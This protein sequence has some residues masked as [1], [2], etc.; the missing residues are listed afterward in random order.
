MKRAIVQVIQPLLA[1]GFE[2]LSFG[3]L[4]GRGRLH[5]LAHAERLTVGQERTVWL[6]QDLK[7]AFDRVP[8]QRA[9]DLLRKRLPNEQLLD[10]IALVK[11]NGS[12]RGLLQGAP[13]S[14][15]ILNVFLDHLK[16][17]VWE[18][19]HPGLPSLRTADDT[20][21]L[22]RSKEE[23]RKAHEELQRILVPTGMM[24]KHAPQRAIRNL[25]TGDN[26]QWLG[27]DI[28]LGKRGLD[29]QPVAMVRAEGALR[30]PR[31]GRS[32]AEEY[33]SAVERGSGA[34]EIAMGLLGVGR[35]AGFS[36][37]EWGSRAGRGC[38]AATHPVAASKCRT[39]TA[40]ESAPV[41][42]DLLAGACRG[43]RPDIPSCLP[44]RAILRWPS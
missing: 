26:A 3:F 35:R 18:K 8:R 41:L 14:P 21:V 40:G 31:V 43:S 23:A 36:R 1:P 33:L 12:K 6:V 44:A 28:R 9:L 37:C 25:A 16:D 22:Y 30:I 20:L 7:D 27:F 13:L 34:D 39:G 2:D 15:L 5:A 42:R 29:P 4:S 32:D 24:L 19:L 11:N 17:K 10:S 38:A